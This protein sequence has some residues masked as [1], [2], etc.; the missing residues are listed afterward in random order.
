MWRQGRETQRVA[1]RGREGSEREA[2]DGG[3]QRTRGGRRSRANTDDT[4]N[5]NHCQRPRQRPPTT[6]R[7]TTSND[8]HDQYHE[9]RPARPTQPPTITSNDHQHNQRQHDEQPRPTT[10]TTRTTSNYQHHQHNH[11]QPVSHTHLRAHET[12]INLASPLL[13]DNTT[14]PH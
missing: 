13:L 1:A 7:A 9:Q 10:T 4:D 6:R 12:S 11:Q 8:Q 5:S 3:Q 14:Q 2:S